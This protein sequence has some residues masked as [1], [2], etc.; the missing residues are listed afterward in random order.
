[1]EKISPVN[2][3]LK[4]PTGSRIHPIF[5]V[6]LLEKAPQNVTTSTD[7]I[8]PEEE[9]DVYDV[10]RILDS[11]ISKKKTEYLVKWLD[12]DDIH[13]TWEPEANLSCPEKLAEYHRR[14]PDRPTPPREVTGRQGQHRQRR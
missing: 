11:R 7:E 9:P 8:Q 5:H 14:N 2:Y 10:E 3:K 6:S 12:W 4:L 13:N 1:M